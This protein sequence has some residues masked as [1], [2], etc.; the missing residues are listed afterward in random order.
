MTLINATVD[1]HADGVSGQEL[2]KI[3]Q[4]RSEQESSAEAQKHVS[5]WISGIQEHT[6]GAAI[7]QLDDGIGGLYDGSPKV[8]IAA[9]TIKVR[10][11][12]KDTLARTKE[13]DEH[14][15]FHL[16]GDHTAD[17]IQ[18]NTMEGNSVVTIGGKEFDETALIE[19]LTVAKTGD[20]FV[21]DQY[22]KYK[23]DLLSSIAAAGINLDDVEQAVNKEKDLRRIDDAARE[24]E[25][26]LAA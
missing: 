1:E 21:S 8:Q 20:R 15:K 14:E 6:K 11:S 22:R 24:E 13:V 26:A 3:V 17:M 18:G 5:E 16:K 12:V 19:G 10:T 4:K 23:Q 9:E 25:Y 2:G 7:K